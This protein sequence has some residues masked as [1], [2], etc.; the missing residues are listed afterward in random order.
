MWWG[1]LVSHRDWSETWMSESFA[2][3]G[4]YL[5]SRHD[6]GEDE[7]ALNLLR[8]KE[9]YLREAHY[10]RPIVFRRWEHPAQNFDSHTHPKGAA[11]LRMLRWI[12]G[13]EAFR[14]TVSRFLSEH[15]FQPVE[16]KGSSIR[17]LDAR[18]A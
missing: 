7:G 3:Y 6:L 9:S 18:A 2:T 4:E 11:V 16:L 13:E 14:R 17:V 12:L 5:F 15:A 8:K 1:D 10:V